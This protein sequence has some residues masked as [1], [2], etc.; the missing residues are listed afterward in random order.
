MSHVRLI[1]TFS[2]FVL[3]F[4]FCKRD[5]TNINKTDTKDTSSEQR[6]VKCCSI[7]ICYKVK[8]TIDSTIIFLLADL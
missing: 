7:C 5:F 4:F 3:Y 2:P 1:V 8:F 6:F